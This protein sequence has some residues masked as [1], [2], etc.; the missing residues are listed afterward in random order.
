MRQ[1]VPIARGR[2]AQ[3]ITNR[4]SLLLEQNYMQRERLSARHRLIE[5]SRVMNMAVPRVAQDT[6]MMGRASPQQH[7]SRFDPL[8]VQ[9]RST[10]LTYERLIRQN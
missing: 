4:V 7:N 6:A 8:P 1:E 9:G 3:P 2:C 5:D 10:Q